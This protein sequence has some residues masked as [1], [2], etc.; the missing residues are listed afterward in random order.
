MKVFLIMA[1]VAMFYASANAA[2]TE[3]GNCDTCANPGALCN[4]CPAAAIMSSDKKSCLACGDGCAMC[5]ADDKD[6]ITCTTCQKANYLNKGACTACADGCGDCV[7]DTDGKTVKCSACQEKFGTKTDEKTSAISC[8]ACSSN[9][10]S[11]TVNTDDSTKCTACYSYKGLA[12]QGYFLK[13]SDSTCAIC[14]S[15]CETCTDNSKGVGICKS[16]YKGYNPIDDT[17]DDTVDGTSCLKCPTTC[18]TCSG[19]KT[20]SDATCTACTADKGTYVS[21]GTCITCGTGAKSCTDKG[22]ISS[23][24][25]EYRQDGASCNKCPAF[26]KQCS[27]DSNSNTICATCNT[28]YGTK[29]TKSVTCDDCGIS[30]CKTCSRLT[31]GTGKF[32][33]TDCKQGFALKSDTE[34]ATCASPC[35]SGEACT[36]ASSKFVCTKCTDESVYISNPGAISGEC[37]QC[38]ASAGKTDCNKCEYD[39]NKVKCTG[40]TFPKLLKSNDGTCVANVD[41]ESGGPNCIK[42]DAAGTACEKCNSGYGLATPDCKQCTDTT[43]C[44]ECDSSDQ[45]ICTKCKGDYV[46]KKSV[47]ATCIKCNEAWID[48]SDGAKTAITNCATCAYSSTNLECKTCDTGYL[49]AD[50][51]L[52]CIA[53]VDTKNQKCKSL[54]S[55]SKVNCAA[56]EDGYGPVTSNTDCPKC[57]DGQCKVC[58]AEANASE[59]KCTTCNDKYITTDAAGGECKACPAQCKQCTYDSTNKKTKCAAAQCSSKYVD[60]TDGT[61]ES[62]SDNCDTCTYDPTA[63]KTVCGT[64]ATTYGLLTAKTCSACPT[65]C[66]SCTI[67]GTGDDTLYCDTCTNSYAK[68]ADV[69]GACPSNCKECANNKGNMECSKCHDFYALDSKKACVKCPTNCNKCTASSSGTKCSDC[70]V[71]YS[72]SADSTACTDCGTAAFL[73]CANCTA[74]DSVSGKAN[75]TACE[76]GYTLQD[77]EEHLSCIDVSSLQ[78]GAGTYSD[79]GPQCSACS[80]SFTLTKSLACGRKCYSCGDADGGVFVEKSKCKIPA[81]GGN[82]TAD[83]ATEIDCLSGICYAALQDGKVVAG[84]LPKKDAIGKCTGDRAAGETCASVGSDANA[85][86]L[87]S[88]CCSTALCNS[89][90]AELDGIP[91]SAITTAVNAMLLVLATMLG[92]RFN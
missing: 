23:C 86:Q 44:E 69:C 34:C 88:Q 70:K 83:D 10:K 42:A 13:K 30:N 50:T 81:I 41:T 91:D 5:T 90:V 82:A 9:C 22:V 71:G 57:N 72:L 60:S 20:G 46:P 79:V 2:C 80:A 21:A 77:G 1:Y 35:K 85:K 52:D 15:F 54:A 40:C 32:K 65:N 43:N 48:G 29:P 45:A 18:A 17:K 76:A 4:S 7:L 74:T 3:L 89:Y 49:L 39:T 64:C 16:C 25:E 87:C 73:G 38:S 37:K 56:C 66:D 55:S 63:K 8:I 26:C 75:C 78:C 92:I 36:Y 67:D 62:C 11:C 59:K 33:C 19:E 61:C 47:G 28:N 27:L 31:D 68:N 14:P 58:A 12:K 53:N 6:K 24:L 84:C 51:K